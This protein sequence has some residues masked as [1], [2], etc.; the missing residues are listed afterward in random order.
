MALSAPFWGAALGIAVL[1]TVRTGNGTAGDTT[2]WIYLLAGLAGGLFGLALLIFHRVW[3]KSQQAQATRSRDWA[4]LL[5]DVFQ[6]FPIPADAIAKNELPPMWQAIFLCRLFNES[7]RLHVFRQTYTAADNA[8]K[9]NQV[10]HVMLSL[11][12]QAYIATSP[13]MSPEEYRE[14]IRVIKN[15]PSG[16][17]EDIQSVAK[18]ARQDKIITGVLTAAKNSSLSSYLITSKSVRQAKTDSGVIG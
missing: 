8:V 2:P 13:A 18:A 15:H 5:T 7:R 6:T 9:A 17:I 1:L 12:L 10:E 11:A 14:L 16:K 3:A 4:Q